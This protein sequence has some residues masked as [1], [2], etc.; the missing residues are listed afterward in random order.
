MIQTVGNSASNASIEVSGKNE[1]ISKKDEE[2][3][4]CV[5]KI[6]LFILIIHNYDSYIYY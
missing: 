5:G 1:E 3:A 2:D 4:T 6:C